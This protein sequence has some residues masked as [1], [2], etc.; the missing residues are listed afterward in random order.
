[1]APPPS[2]WPL[3]WLL[4]AAGL[5]AAAQLGKMSALAPWLVPA[6]GLSLTTMAWAISLL[7]SGGAALG[8]V[9]GREA[10]RF[11]LWPTLRAGV[12][13]LAVAG[14]GQC[15]ADGAGGL[16]AW[17]LLEALGYLGVTV[18]APV[19]ITQQAARIGPR[20]QG[21]AL[22]LWSTFVPV[23][24]ALGAALSAALAGAWG[25]RLAMA[26]SGALGVALAL[27]LWRRPGVADAGDDAPDADSEAV[28]ATAALPSQ[29]AP[30]R[31]AF[32]PGPADPGDPHHPRDSG[33]P[34][35]P[36]DP[37][38]RDPPDPAD[39]RNPRDPDNPSDPSDP[40][41]RV[42]SHDRARSHGVLAGI[43][44]RALAL[45]LAFGGFALFQVGMIGLLPTLL[46]DRAGLSPA[47]AGG[48]SG[49]ASASA[50]L[51][52]AWAAWLMRH[53]G[54]PRW[55]LMGA[56]ALPALLLP[57]VFNASPTAGLAVALAVAI[58]ALGGVFAGLA[59]ARLPA[60]SDGSATGLVR[61]NGL[62]AQC[63]ASGSLLG[64]PTMAACVAWGG[65]LTAAAWGAVVA[66]A[67]VLLAWRATA[68]A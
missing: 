44:P 47:Q 5:L 16:L 66:L 52:S 37:R 26:C 15:L 14:L 60:V 59:F 7:E 55:P 32:S 21:L 31:Q 8:L 49:V 34:S 23:G 20:A 36:H 50:V 17:R 57:G 54:Q 39:R 38:P 13:A 51:G 10:S 53:G 29:A 43:S 56:L 41:D 3:I 63:G 18:T 46:V 58:Q 64:P 2:P 25:W 11:G 45:T 68:R 12:L 48:W 61:I 19:L 28:V 65:W 6:L 22:S 62:L 9:S 67:A 27:A 24:L 30:H 42:P 33:N 35:D 40:R 4:Y 1:M